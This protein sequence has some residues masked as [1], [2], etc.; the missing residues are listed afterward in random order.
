MSMQDLL[1]NTGVSSS[2]TYHF[3]P[4]GKEEL[5]ASAVRDSGLTSAAQIAEVMNEHDPATAVTRIFEAA[6]EEVRSH[7]FT[8]DCPIGVTATEAAHDSPKR[9]TARRHIE[10]RRA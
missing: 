7:D 10:M 8:L 5:V 9:H 4:G 1:R 6:A 2:S 3:L